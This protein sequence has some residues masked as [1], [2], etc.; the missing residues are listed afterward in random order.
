MEINVTIVAPELVSA[1]NT[2]ACALDNWSRGVITSQATPVASAPAAAFAPVVPSPESVVE[3]RAADSAS[4]A[5]EKK[6]KPE[7]LRAALQPL[8][9]LIS[10]QLI[11]EFCGKAPEERPKLSDV[12]AE[13]HAELVAEANRLAQQ[14]ENLKPAA[15]ND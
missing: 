15:A 14:P 1:I 2:L 9:S 6:I 12:P 7:D 5:K 4:A 11:A 13:K 10:R 3:T 8:K